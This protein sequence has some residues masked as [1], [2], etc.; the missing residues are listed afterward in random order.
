TDRARRVAQ[1]V[2]MRQMEV[3]PFFPPMSGT[4]RAD[5]TERGRARSRRVPARLRARSRA[6]PAPGRCAG[7]VPLCGGPAATHGPPTAPRAPVTI[8]GSGLQRGDQLSDGQL[9]LRRVV[10]VRA[11][12]PRIATLRCPTDTRHAGLGVFPD[13]NVG[14]SVIGRGSYLGRRTVRVRAFAAP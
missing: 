8:P 4:I 2:G 3:L 9:L 14:F 1:A 10:A 7:R 5:R 12:R 11:P 13:A 6:V